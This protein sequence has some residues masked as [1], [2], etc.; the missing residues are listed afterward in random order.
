MKNFKKIVATGLVTAVTFGLS[1]LGTALVSANPAC[2]QYDPSGNFTTSN[3]PVFNNICGDTTQ[4]N[5]TDGPYA[6]GNESNFVRIR[7]DT[8]GDVT[9]N[10]NNPALTN[11]VTSACTDGSKFDV[12]TYV[13]NDAQ[14]SANDNGAGT[15]VA[16]NVQLAL[17][18]AGV[19]TETGDNGGTFTFG[20]TVSASNAET[21][22]DT[23]SLVCN[24]HKVK[25]T[26]VPSSVHYTLNVANPTY[27]GLPDSAVNGTTALGNPTFGSGNVWGCWDFRTVVVYQVV[28]QTVT[29]QP[30]ITATCD[31]F[32]IL[33][34]SDRK[35]TVN[36]FGATHKNVNI[37]NVVVSWGD[38]TDG[39]D[40][41]TINIVNNDIS[42]VS[43]GTVT[44]SF[45]KD[46][47]YLVSALVNFDNAPSAGG[48]G[49][50]SNCL[51]S[52]TFSP[53]T[54]PTVTPP[55]IT[56][57][58]PPKQLINTGPGEVAG[59]FS[60][61]SAASA[62]GYRKFLSRRLSR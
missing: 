30:E 13:H 3:T 5:S 45:A 18:A 25:L 41:Q 33:A 37:K 29:V 6:F 61:V 9:S 52:V 57:T 60:G 58:T 42:V 50:G 12:W 32:T 31:F 8:S 10:R 38:T 21:V 7:P 48:T 55:H 36:T 62:L 40:D 47:T 43:N 23:A 56:V 44:H 11:Q 15:A 35:V 34:N 51:E 24:G 53:A 27:A 59:L 4:L 39:S 22:T 54:P 1:M 46:G 49:A 2:F 14:A 26:L 17:A 20:S 19:G 16:H 28:V